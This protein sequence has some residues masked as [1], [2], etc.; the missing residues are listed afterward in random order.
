MA[1][2]ARAAE[3]VMVLEVIAQFQSVLPAYLKALN[4]TGFF[5]ELDSSVYTRA[6]NFAP[7]RGDEVMHR[8]GTV[9]LEYHKD[10]ASGLRNTLAVKTQSLF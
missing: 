1:T 10:F 2:E 7:A 3:V 5:K 6:V 8:H 4:D 9:L